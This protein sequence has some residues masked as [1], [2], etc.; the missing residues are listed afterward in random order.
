MAFELTAAYVAAWLTGIGFGY[1]LART[2]SWRLGAAWERYVLT[3]MHDRP[4]PYLL[5]QLMLAMPYLGTNLTMLPLIIAVGLLLWLK[6]HQ[7]LIA[8]HLLVVS[9]GSLSLNPTMKYLL[10]RPRPALFPLRGMWTWASYPSGHLILTTALYFTVSLMLQRTFGWRWP[11]AA[12]VVVILL[13]AYSRVYLAVH[14][15]TDM[16]GGLLI[17]IVWL[18]GTWTAFARYRRAVKKGDLARRAADDLA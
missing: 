3:W 15:P 1:L 16:I 5:D 18:V 4:L 8:I 14:W 9:I 2:D 7:R 6:Y 17:G 11:Y 10:N 13:T 12:S